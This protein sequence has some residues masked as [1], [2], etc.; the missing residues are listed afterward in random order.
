MLSS[1]FDFDEFTKKLSE[2]DLDD[3]KVNEISELSKKGY[4]LLKENLTER[5]SDCFK[6]IIDLDPENNYALVGLGDAYRKQ[7][8]I[9]GCRGLLSALSE[10]SSGQ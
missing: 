9:Q 4:Q 1:D 10:I 6:Q 5:A 2:N 8:K 7:K 3:E